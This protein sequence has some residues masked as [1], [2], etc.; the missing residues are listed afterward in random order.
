AEAVEIV[1][2]AC[3]VC[4]AEQL[5]RLVL[6]AA[7]VNGTEG[8]DILA[9]PELSPTLFGD[10]SIHATEILER[11]RGGS[12]D[13]RDDGFAGGVRDRGLTGGGWRGQSRGGSRAWSVDPAHLAHQL[14][15]LPLP[16][17]TVSP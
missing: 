12:E 15:P 6:G 5:D 14:L 4:R 3:V 13:P 1:V 8:P 7:E 9:E 2:E 10:L 16:P 17:A 11:W